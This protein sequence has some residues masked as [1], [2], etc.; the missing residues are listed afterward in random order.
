MVKREIKEKVRK[1][2]KVVGKHF[3]VLMVILYGSFARGQEREYSDI[4]I[5][6]LVEDQPDADYLDQTVSLF[7]LRDGIDIRIEPKLYYK[8]DYE[9][10]EEASF[11]S[12]ILRTG[13]V[14]Y[15]NPE[16]AGENI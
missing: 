13:E 2:A 6:V 14:I 8:K 5:A 1:Y 7:K 9:Q 11:L 4:D 10:R 3:D 12:E 15:R 16:F